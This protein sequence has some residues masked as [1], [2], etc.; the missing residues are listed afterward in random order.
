MYVH[1]ATYKFSSVL[2]MLHVNNYYTHGLCQVCIVQS[3]DKQ[4]CPESQMVVCYITGSLSDLVL[5][6]SLLHTSGIHCLPIFVK[7]SHF[8]LSDVISKRITFS[9]HFLPPTEPPA[10]APWFFLRYRRYINHLLTYLLSTAKT[11]C[12]SLLCGT[13]KATFWQASVCPEQRGRGHLVGSHAKVAL[14]AFKG[15]DQTNHSEYLV[16]TYS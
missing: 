15:V 6:T 11:S 2:C 10:N 14:T 13:T 9:Q 3:I 7:P 4:W 5:S 8:L 16:Q 12:N 1:L